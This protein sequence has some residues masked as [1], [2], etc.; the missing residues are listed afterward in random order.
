MNDPHDDALQGAEERV[1]AGDPATAV[2]PSEAPEGPQAAQPQ[3]FPIGPQSASLGVASEIAVPSIDFFASGANLDSKPIVEALDV[4][5]PTVP[6]QAHEAG[7]SGPR[8]SMPVPSTP[9]PPAEAHEDEAMAVANTPASP[10]E[11]QQGGGSVASAGGQNA[12][13]LPEPTR[14]SE[15]LTLKNARVG[16]DY[17]EPLP[18]AGLQDLR[19]QQPVSDIGIHFDRATCALIGNPA[20]AGDFEWTI[21]GLRDQT[22]VTLTVR[23]AVIPDPR[24]LWKDVDSEPEAAFWKP[25]VHHDHL[26]GEVYAVA[27]SKRGRSH[28]HDGRFRDD[29]FALTTTGP[30]GWHVAAVADGAGSAKYSRQGSMIAVN[31]VVRTLPGAMATTVTPK[32]DSIVNHY[33]AD[34]DG[35]VDAIRAVLYEAVVTTAFAAAKAVE[36][37]ARAARHDP[38][39][40]STTLI[41]SAMCRIEQG[42]FVATFSVGDGG[43]ALLDIP[44]GVVQVMTTPDGGEFAGQTRFLRTSEFS[45]SAKSMSRIHFALPSTFTALVL[46]TDGISDPKFPTDVAFAEFDRWKEF[47]EQDLTPV[48]TLDRDNAQAGEQLSAW[49]DF[50]SDGNHDDRTLA[51]LLP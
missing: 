18:I 51:V 39:D 42:W 34:P 37:F 45:E 44:A 40:Y 17:E 6:Q 9:V 43:A 47:W 48:V 26:H 25:D 11:S 32:I 30:G 46:M 49:M 35:S 22:P 31:H 33:N 19:V 20:L 14:A 10:D 1:S 36:S 23:I 41:M 8:G 24:S 12:Y 50:W 28:A 13:R 3:E 27:A 15:T 7:S 38:N 21:T 5:T 16:Q 29:D 2:S 4:S